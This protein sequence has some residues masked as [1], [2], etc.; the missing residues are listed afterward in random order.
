MVEHV[1]M[2]NKNKLHGLGLDTV[3]NAPR[4]GQH[5]RSNIKRKQK[6]LSV[7]VA[8]E[9]TQ[10]S[11]KVAKV[12]FE[13]VSWCRTDTCEEISNDTKQNLTRYYIF[14][15]VLASLA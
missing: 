12:A 8:A 14:Y 5:R 4:L 13:I 1:I 3:H 7:E 10:K 6:L 2:R 11:T 15:H 9:W